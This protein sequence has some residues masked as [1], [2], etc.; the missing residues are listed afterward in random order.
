A[1]RESILGRGRELAPR[2]VSR[3]GGPVDLKVRILERGPAGGMLVVHVLVDCRDAMGANLVNTIAEGIAEPLRAI[4]RGKIGLRILSNL[5]DQR[6]VTV[7]ARVPDH[8]LAADPGVPGSGA[9]VRD[10]IV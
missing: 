1:A 10:A 3:G 9:A 8:A 4:A 6:L 7:T 2:L 5:A